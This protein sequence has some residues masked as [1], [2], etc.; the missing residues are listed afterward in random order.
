MTYTKQHK[1]DPETSDFIFNYLGG[2]FSW[3]LKRKDSVEFRTKYLLEEAQYL[4][5]T[6]G[7]YV[8][9]EIPS[10]FTASDL[11]DDFFARL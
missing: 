7:K 11:V 8:D 4:I 6:N 1:L 9:C 2:F 3:S 5:N 10:H